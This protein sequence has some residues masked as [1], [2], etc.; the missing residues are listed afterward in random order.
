MII[1][2]FAFANRA[3]KYITFCY[4]QFSFKIVEVQTAITDIKNIFRKLFYSGF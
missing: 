2:C 4:T 3:H 1:I